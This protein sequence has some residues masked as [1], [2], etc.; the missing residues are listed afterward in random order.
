M[1]RTLG[2]VLFNL[3]VIAVPLAALAAR[4]VSF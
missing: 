2:A 1:I 4:V 3:A